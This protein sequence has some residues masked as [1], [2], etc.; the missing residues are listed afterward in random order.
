MIV[1]NLEELLKERG[2]T[3][4]WLAGE[5]GVRYQRLLLHKRSKAQMIKFDTLEKICLAL[6]C[7]P[8]DLLEIVSSKKR[9]K[10][11]A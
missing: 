9:K 10:K 7:A 6:E 4:Y 3:L 8:G 1:S 11:A 5:T 2:R